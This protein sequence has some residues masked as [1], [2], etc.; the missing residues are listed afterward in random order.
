LAWKEKEDGLVDAIINPPP[1]E[2]EEK[3][4]Q[5]EEEPVDLEQRALDITNLR[6]KFQLD[7]MKSNEF[8]KARFDNLPNRKVVKLHKLFKC[9]FYFL[10]FSS[11]SICIEGTQVFCWKKARH[12]WNEA[13]L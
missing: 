4:E 7:L 12:L 5:E 3:E 2:G 10:E 9:I 8:L 11:E 1:V 6:I 13:L